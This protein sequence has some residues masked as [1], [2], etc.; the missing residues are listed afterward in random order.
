MALSWRNRTV[1][2]TATVDTIADGVAGRHPLPEVLDD[3]LEVVDDVVL[4]GEDSIKAGMRHLFE[5]GGLVG[6]PSAALGLAALLEDRPR[7]Q[8]RT[9]ATVICGRNVAPTDFRRWTTT[10]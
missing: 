5:L 2:T 3:L 9:A 4:V 10:A 7:F 8:D 6:E 1:V